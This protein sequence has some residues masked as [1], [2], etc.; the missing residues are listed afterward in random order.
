MIEEI[1]I[2]III[3]NYNQLQLLNHCLKSI[4]KFTKDVSY[5]IIIVDNNSTDG[6]VE[7]ITSKFENVRLIKNE[8]N[9]GFS[10]AN[11]KGAKLAKGKYLLILNN[12]VEFIQNSIKDIFDYMEMC[13][14]DKLV[15]CKLLNK[16]HSIQTSVHSFPTPINVI[17]ANLFINKIFPNSQRLN[18][19]YFMKIAIEEPNDTLEVEALFG[20]F[21]FLLKES[22]IELDGFDENFHF[23][24]EDT[25]FCFRFKNKIGSVIYFKS[26]A[27]IHY[28]GST[29][30]N[31]LW[32]HYK[33][34]T[35][36]LLKYMKK[37]FSPVPF[38]LTAF[39]HYL[40]LLIRVPTNFLIGII[41]L[42]K[43]MI[44]KAFYLFRC[45]FMIPGKNY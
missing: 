28:G 45:L 31:Y 15:G 10:K 30:Q 16:D 37:H 43:N 13:E 9:E 5:E 3:V 2:T 21:L 34:R 4:Q 40:G 19:N 20:A 7:E 17:S 11:N 1:D 32:F 36:S 27:V 26:T 38:L 35:L 6:D 22:F 42:D 41:T 33:N 18:K 44:L 25:D 29:S 14:I 23:Y 39:F 8:K 12:D 24:H